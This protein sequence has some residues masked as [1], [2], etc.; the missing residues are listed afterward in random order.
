MKKKNNLYIYIMI[1]RTNIAHQQRFFYFFLTLLLVFLFSIPIF[2]QSKISNDPKTIY[3]KILETGG[4]FD[5]KDLG[6]SL[7]KLGKESEPYIIQLLK[8]DHYWNRHAGISAGTEF[9]SPAINDSLLN[10]FIK[11]HMVSEDIKTLILSKPK[12]FED[13][14]INSWK[15]ETGYDQKKK[16]LEVMQ[17]G[18]SPKITA[19]LKKEISEP[20]SKLRKEAFLSLS[21]KAKKNEDEFLRSFLDDAV[22]RVS[23]LQHIYTFG[24]VSDKEYMIGI[25]EEDTSPPEEKT[26]ALHSMKKWGSF[27]EQRKELLRALV[28]KKNPAGISTQAIYLFGEIRSPEIRTE[29]CRHAQNG[30]SQELRLAASESLI[31]YQE[32]ANRACIKRISEENYESQSSK[33]TMGDVIAGIFTLGFT[34]IMNAIKENQTRDAFL[35][36]QNR[37]KEH[38]KFLDL[39]AKD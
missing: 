26:I 22:L 17:D 4:L 21:S 16:L 28:S 5:K 30:S 2:P 11:D 27:S 38:I 32:I 33:T 29:L 8:N 13:G 39:M 12:R 19:I 37:I 3:N 36:R 20:A 23:V 15:K 34:P 25:L 6:T 9:S 18:T 14:I 7:G 10:L 24:S 31:P 1:H 35:A